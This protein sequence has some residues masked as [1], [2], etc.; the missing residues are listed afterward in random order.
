MTTSPRSGTV[1]LSLPASALAAALNAVRFAVGKDP[2]LPMLG[3]VLFEVEGDALHV[4]AT[5]RYRMAVAR[6]D[7]VRHGE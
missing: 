5:D 7:A 1:H 2:D 4:V 3:G 6:T